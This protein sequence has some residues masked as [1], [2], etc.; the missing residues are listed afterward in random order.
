MRARNALC[1]DAAIYLGNAAVTIV[2]YLGHGVL[3]TYDL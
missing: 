1:I 2:V 3:S